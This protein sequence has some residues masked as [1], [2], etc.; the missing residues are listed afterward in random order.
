[1]KRLTTMDEVW[2]YARGCT[3]PW[4]YC[5]EGKAAQNAPGVQGWFLRQ[6]YRISLAHAKEFSRMVQKYN[7]QSLAENT[8]GSRA[9][10][11][12]LA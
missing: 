2:D 11:A 6:G 7:S 1:M 12:R 4:E 8:V 5:K 9:G 3:W 10:Q